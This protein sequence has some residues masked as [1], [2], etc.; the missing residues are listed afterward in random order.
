MFAGAILAACAG[1]PD[2]LH[3]VSG[4]S[5]NPE[6]RVAFT[7]EGWALAMADCL[8][9]QGFEPVVEG[10]GVSVGKFPTSQALAVEAAYETCEGEME[11]IFIDL[12]DGEPIP[13]AELEDMYR[14]Q[15]GVAECLELHGYAVPAPP[16]MEAWVDSYN[17]E[18]PWDPYLGIPAAVSTEEEWR[19]INDACPQALAT[20]SVFWD[21]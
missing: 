4:E 19:S 6:P 14:L 3:S 21:E 10:A 7:A 1:V 11:S 16:S 13:E 18:A 12:P 5:V 15:T 20:V 8:R 17:E 9:G 2:T